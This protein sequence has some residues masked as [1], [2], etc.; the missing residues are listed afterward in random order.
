M[1]RPKHAPCVAA[2]ALAAV[3]NPLA[4]ETTDAPDESPVPYTEWDR[5]TGDWNGLRTNLEDAGLSINGEYTLEYSAVYSGG[6]NTEDSFRNLL[7]LDVEAD[8]DTLF[9]LEGGTF[10]IQY[11]SASAENGGSQDA[12]DIQAFSNLE[13]DRSLD[14]VYELWFQ[15]VLF[16]DRLRIKLGKIDANTEFA[17][18][19]TGLDYSAAGEF[20]HSTAGFAPTL[21]GFP[22]Y[23]DPA[24]GISLFYTPVQTDNHT[25][26]LAYGFFDGALG[27]DGIETGRRGPS[28]F[29]NDD[30]SDDYFHIAEAQLVWTALGPLPEG[31]LSLGGWYHT[32]DFPE[33]AGGTAD[34][35]GGLYLTVQQRLLAPEGPDE[36]TGL[37]VFAQGGWSNPEV[38]E[39]E[40][41]YAIGLTQVG[42]GACRP[43]DRVGL[44]AALAVLTDEPAAGFDDDELALEAFY[45][46]QITPAVYLQ[47]GLHYIINPSGNPTIDDALVGVCRFGVTF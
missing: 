29:F 20:T 41:T 26:T 21:L 4:A 38:A 42:L 31:S 34:G 2:L 14:A 43:D 3:A 27:V 30:R 15:Q 7:V 37:Y 47:P 9:G 24:T 25:L 11:Q 6:L 10:F 33:F 18:V 36:E 12:G 5:A 23:P 35:T 39:V 32:G 28:T 44:Y 45:R 17:A 13:V 46:L 16:D 8:L 1:N 22:S 19:G 40:Q